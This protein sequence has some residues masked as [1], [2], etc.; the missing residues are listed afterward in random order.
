MRRYREHAEAI[1]RRHG[2]RWVVVTGPAR[3][4]AGYAYP[5]Q[6]VVETGPIETF[7]DFVVLLHEA[8]HVVERCEP[9]HHPITRPGSRVCVGCE[10]NA[11]LKAAAWA[12]E[13]SLAA[14]LEMRRCL[15]TYV[16]YAT[17]TECREIESL[18][19]DTTYRC[20]LHRSVQRQ[21]ES[22]GIWT[23]RTH[24]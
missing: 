16:K 19:S 3:G 8:A 22:E 2:I 6:R 18:T 5:G 12:L 21:L 4:M 20:L 9:H 1:L 10:V 7:V 23:Q 17:P 14:H 11:W 15:R 13:W 24:R